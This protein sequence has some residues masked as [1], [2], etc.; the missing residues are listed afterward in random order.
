MDPFRP[1]KPAPGDELRTDETIAIEALGHLAADPER[2]H[3]FFAL[4]GIGPAGL[5]AAAAD[6]RFLGGVLEFYAGDEK[7]LLDLAAA[8]GRDPR[9]I[10]AARERLC[11]RME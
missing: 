3:R 9:R 10:A 4:T 6:P 11:G 1:P 2:L 7:S 8:T 5:R